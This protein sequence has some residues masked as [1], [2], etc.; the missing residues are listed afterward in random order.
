MTMEGWI[1]IHRNIVNHW[2][3]KKAIW[4]AWWLDLLLMAAWEERQ[5]PVGNQLITLHKGQMI[6]SLS[7]LCKRWKHS[8]TMIEPYLDLLQREDMITKEVCKNVSIITIKN[9]ARY[10]AVDNAYLDAHL[11]DS[12]SYSYEHQSTHLNAYLDTHLDAHPNAYLDATIKESK[13]YNNNKDKEEIL[14]KDNIKEEKKVS[15]RFVKPTVEQI[16]DYC[17]GRG[18]GIDAQSF[19]DFYESKG[20][21]V[22]KS[23]MK[24]WKACVRTWE[25]RERDDKPKGMDVGVILKERPK[26]TKGW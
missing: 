26:Y 3:F 25:K 17:R 19:Y 14:S 4:M 9:Y 7:F 5:Q 2:I 1:K 24:D 13:E 16:A 18:N 22:G 6:A 11:N 10:Q 20:W 15:A 23:P 21:V 12:D 8:R